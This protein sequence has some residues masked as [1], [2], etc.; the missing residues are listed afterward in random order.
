MSE[1]TI[2]QALR[3]AARLKGRL[4]EY[5]TRAA[6]SVTFRVSSKPAYNFAEVLK[7]VESARDE[8]IVLESR[9]AITNAVTRIEFS[10]KQ[11][12]LTQAVKMLQE[13]KGEL[14]WLKGLNVRQAATTFDDEVVYIKGEHTTQQVPVACDLPE[15]MRSDR[16]DEVQSAFD[17]LNDLVER[18]NHETP[19]H[20]A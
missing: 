1:L 2:S 15:A 7:K 9:L 18:K 17:A 3:N 20:A 11:V 8:L 12:T 19:L 6:A 5:R 16:M 13:Y 4:A 10:G 14:A